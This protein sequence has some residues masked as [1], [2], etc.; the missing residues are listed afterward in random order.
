MGV[1]ELDRLRHMY[2]AQCKELEFR[3]GRQNEAFR[4]GTAVFAAVI[5]ATLFVSG[6]DQP[7][8]ERSYVASMLVSVVLVGVIVF[9]LKWQMK[10]RRYAGENQK[11]LVKIQLAMGY[12]DGR[13]AFPEEWNEW[14]TRYQTLGSQLKQPSKELATLC[15]GIASI[16]SVWAVVLLPILGDVNTRRIKMNLKDYAYSAGILATF[17]ISVWNLVQGNRRARKIS[18][19]NTVTS[20]RVKWLE[21]LRQDIA[22]YCGLTYTWCSSPPATETE[23]QEA[24]KQ[25]D[26]LRHLI[27]LRLNPSESPDREIISLVTEMPL[28]TDASRRPDLLE[29]L[30]KLIHET[31][32]LLKKEWDKVKD[33]AKDGDLRDLSRKSGDSARKRILTQSRRV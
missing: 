29:S 9:S 6:G 19:I 20:Q 24:L 8:F 23:N 27:P 1:P 13:A 11:A 22:T 32:T 4:L 26:R 16:L 31:Q 33:E 17:V 12:F 18:F 14:G 30:Q 3:R 2:E 15:L 5:G 7:L 25:I 28:L 10:Q 21:Q